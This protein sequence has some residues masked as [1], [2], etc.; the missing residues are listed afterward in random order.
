MTISLV[1]LLTTE[2]LL[3]LIYRRINLDEG[4]YLNAAKLVYE[5]KVLY[6]DFAYTQTPV[7]PY[8]YGL[9]QQL[10]GIGLYQGRILTVLLALGAFLLSA[11]TARRLAGPRAGVIALALL[12]TSF[13]A[14]TQYTYTAT[15]ALTA[16][17]LAA[18]FYVALLD[19]RPDPRNA[20]ATLF[21]CLAVGTRLSTVVCLPPVLLYLWLTSERKGRAFLVIGAT[22]IVT[23]GVVLGL[24]WLRSGELMVY[25]I[26]GFH[27]D[28][29][30]RTRWR[31]LKI[32]NRIL[33]TA[34]DFAAPLLLCSWAAIWAGRRLWR[35][36]RLQLPVRNPLTVLTM[37]LVVAGLFV[38]HLVPRTTDSYYNALQMPLMSVIGAVVVARQLARLSDRGKGERQV[39]SSWV[40]WLLIVALAGH[41]ALQLRALLRDGALTDPLQNQVAVVRD[42]A[43]LVRHYV[44][45]G[46][47]LLTFNQHLALEADR[48]TP[49][50]YEMAIFAYRPTWDAD[51]ALRY[52]VINNTMLL[53]DLA[54][55]MALAAFT[56]FD[57]E[58][59]YGERGT[60]F[61]IL[62]TYY[63]WFYTI[64]HFGPYGDIL[65]LYVPPQ[66]AVQ[67]PSIAYPATF[68]DGIQ[69]LGYDLRQDRIQEQPVL[70]VALYWQ[71]AATPSQE[72]TVFV[73]LLDANGAFVTGFDNPP[74]HRTC[75]TTTWQPGEFLRDE[76]QLALDGLDISSPFQ[77]QIGMYNGEG[78]RLDVLAGNYAGEDRII[79]QQV[80]LHP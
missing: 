25:D 38:A 61:A 76:Y 7:L 45:A 13:F 18:A 34:F 53:D 77:L 75:P 68:A 80:E 60:F 54:R 46:Q 8:V 31:L 58:Q 35:N 39:R 1:L 33:R 40:L 36:R 48:P 11:A 3:L 55:P 64:P 15:Y 43:A 21:L 57:L 28:R 27:L 71:A 22:T 20:L 17:F 42:A 72:Y 2:L 79:L 56:E 4:W 19:W 29:I 32:Q 78:T 47:P 30:L 50:G 70:D 52:K 23:L 49:P 12:A 66:F 67:S 5:G 9:F 26:W 63:R 37:V 6:Q 74:C 44:P 51:Q 24:F 62:N 14:A 73:Q 16:Y 65:Y 69:L 59:L 41:G 10:F